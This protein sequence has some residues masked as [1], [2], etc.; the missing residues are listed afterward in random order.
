MIKKVFLIGGFGNN[1]FQI[2]KGFFYQDMGYEVVYKTVLLE[3]SFFTKILGWSNHSSKLTLE[4]LSEFRYERGILFSELLVIF[5]LLIK[6][7]L[8][9]FNMQSFN[10]QRSGKVEIGYWQDE[11]I[12]NERF[13]S[14][15]RSRFVDEVDDF[16]IGSDGV[17]VHARLGD[18]APEN[19][20]PLSY[21]YSSISKLDCNKVFLVTDTPSFSF[22]LQTFLTANGWQG[23]VTVI[24]SGSMLE[25][26]KILSFSHSLVM[27]N[28][29]FCYWA[30]QLVPVANVC[31]P[32]MRRPGVLWP[33]PMRNPSAFVAKSFNS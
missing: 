23:N 33:F 2:N 3:N 19:R 16:K 15:L 28:S 10:L 31:Y 22:D 26:F 21:Y 24:D 29:T 8:G 7:K 18:F 6:K 32:E 13:L 12:L 4:L 14:F 25:D 27:S 30:S 5:Y 9:F 11:L 17:I 1:L 20:V